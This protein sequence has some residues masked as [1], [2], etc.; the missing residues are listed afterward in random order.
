M[1]RLLAEGSCDFA[2]VRALRA[3]GFDVLPIAEDSAGADD[4]RG[5]A[6]GLQEGRNLLTEDRDFWQR[7]FASGRRSLGIVLIRFPA[8]ARP[9]LGVRRPLGPGCSYLL[10]LSG[11]GFATQAAKCKAHA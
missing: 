5:I 4:Q 9:S 11:H 8:G 1:L 2:A 10:A 6:L 3:E 7:V